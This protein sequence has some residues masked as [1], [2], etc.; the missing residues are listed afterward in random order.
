M[1]RAYI[2]LI[3]LLLSI[4]NF[5]SCFNDSENSISDRNDISDNII[6]ND[7]FF[8]GSHWND[9]HVLYRNGQF[10]MYASSDI[11]WNGIVQIYRLTSIDGVNWSISNSGNPVFQPAAS[12]WD[13]HCVETP[14]VVYFNG[15]YHLFY[16]GYDVE[17]DYTASDGN[18]AADGD[19]VFDDDMASKHFRIGHAT[20]P[21]GITWTRDNNNPLI[22]PSD[23]YNS[24]NLNFNQYTVAEPAPV[25]FNN[26]IYLYFT[27]VGADLTV[28][29]TWQTIG[30]VKS[31][32]DASTWTAPQQ[33]LTPLLAQYPRT[34]G[35]EYI[36]FSTP[37]AVILNG[38]VHL[39]VDVVL[40]SPWTQDKIHHAYSADGE[41]AWTQDNSPL[42]DRTDY[43]WTV[44]EIRS[45]SAL[46]YDNKLYL[47]FAGHYLDGGN[48]ILGIGLKIYDSY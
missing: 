28:G 5:N 17:Y 18:G 30:L 10:E 39:F 1:K 13:S 48:P 34:T 40:N 29:T 45:P 47:Y 9:P 36:G 4:F 20:S 38:Q 24:P 12:G 32:A 26:K 44:N 19:T 21:D 16:T 46:E 33:V 22:S 6:T 35:S 41:S 3:F 14:A 37:N 31:N 25:V 8:P 7:D 27:A 2:F 42:M 15:E 43:T 23:P 11:S